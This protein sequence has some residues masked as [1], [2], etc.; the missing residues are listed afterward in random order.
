MVLQAKCVSVNCPAY[1]L[2]SIPLSAFSS[3]PLSVSVLTITPC[4]Y[5]YVCVHVH[6]CIHVY[7]CVEI[8][9]HVLWLCAYPCVYVCVG[10]GARTQ[11]WDN[12]FLCS[13]LS[14]VH[15]VLILYFLNLS[16]SY[17]FYFIFLYSWQK[18]HCIYVRYFYYTLSIP[19][20][21]SRLVPFSCYGEYS[22]SDCGCT[23]VFVVD[24]GRFRGCAQESYSWII[25]H[26]YCY[27]G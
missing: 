4:I 22:N 26:L 3:F 15:L 8:Y 7:I 19:W 2:L 25:W 17:R 13:F 9:V 20:W 5:A 10:V 24:Y 14:L 11:I 21:A 12:T 18:S 6:V 1:L 27:L 23:Q 16:I